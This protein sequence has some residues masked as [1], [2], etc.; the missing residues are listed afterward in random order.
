MLPRRNSFAWYHE[1][2]PQLLA[3]SLNVRMVHHIMAGNLYIA[4]CV[5][6]Q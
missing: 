1:T 6:M 5:S 4:K 2:A 3:F